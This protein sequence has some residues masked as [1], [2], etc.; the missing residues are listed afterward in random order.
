MTTMLTISPLAEITTFGTDKIALSLVGRR[1]TIEDPTGMLKCMLLSTK[2]GISQ[3][4][5][6]S[7]LAQDYPTDAVTAAIKALCDLNLF[8]HADQNELQRATSASQRCATATHLFLAYRRKCEHIA[9]TDHHASGNPSDWKLVV[10]GQ[11]GFADAITIAL[12]Q[13]NIQVRQ[14]NPGDDLGTHAQANTHSDTVTTEQG[15]THYPTLLLA[16]SDFEDFTFFRNINKQAMALAIPTLYLNLDWSTAQC[17]P[18]VIPNASACYECYFHRLRATRKFLEE[19]DARSNTEHILIH[20]L[21]NTLAIQYGT[22]EA[23]RIVLQFL[24]GILN[25]MH[26]GLFSEMDSLTGDIHRSQII[27]LPRCPVCGRANTHRPTGTV[28]QR[29]ILRQGAPT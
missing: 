19:F 16:C 5:L 10:I 9:A 28:F 11:G 3:T 8:I 22:A 21:P 7:L 24:S 14:L 17:G 15:I 2:K 13:L 1:L 29:A 23:A 18:L 25:N 26:Q 27:R 4:E 6:V 20:A 12:T